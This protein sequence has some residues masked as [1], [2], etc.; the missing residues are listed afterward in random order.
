MFI[1][2][3]PQA[4][5]GMRPRFCFHWNLSVSG[6]RKTWIVNLQTVFVVLPWSNCLLLLISEVVF[7]FCIAIFIDKWEKYIF[8]LYN[9][10]LIFS[11]SCRIRNSRLRLCR[12]SPIF[13]L[14]VYKTSVTAVCLLDNVLNIAQQK[15]KLTSLNSTSKQLLHRKTI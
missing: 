5:V 13:S 6:N 9:F 3:W 2:I 15:T 8:N 7:F 1:P 11:L 12:L 10:F 4:F 14:I